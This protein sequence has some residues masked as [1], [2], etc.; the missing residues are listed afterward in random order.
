MNVDIGSNHMGN[1]AVHS[2]LDGE[3]AIEINRIDH[4]P[5]KPPRPHV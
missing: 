5:D 4:V 3:S 1:I 2:D